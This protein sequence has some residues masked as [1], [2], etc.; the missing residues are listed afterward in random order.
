MQVAGSNPIF[1]SGVISGSVAGLMAPAADLM[2]CPTVFSL[3]SP[4]LTL[5]CGQ[6]RGA[7]AGVEQQQDDR[8][9]TVDSW[10][11]AS[12]DLTVLPGLAAVARGQLPANFFLGQRFHHRCFRIGRVDPAAGGPPYC[13][14]LAESQLERQ[15]TLISPGASRCGM[16]STVRAG[17]GIETLAGD[18]A[19]RCDAGEARRLELR[20]QL[21]RRRQPAAAGSHGPPQIEHSRG[22]DCHPGT[23]SSAA[24]GPP[25]SGS[26]GRAAAAPAGRPPGNSRCSGAGSPDR[27]PPQV[28]GA[29]C[30]RPLRSPGRSSPSSRCFRRPA[31]PQLPAARRRRPSAR[32]SVG[33]PSG[34]TPLSRTRSPAA[35]TGRGRGSRG[36]AP[37]R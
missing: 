24:G 2:V 22:R 33:W 14:R 4:N 29:G 13:A 15:R 26:R 18:Q 37:R 19:V 10:A 21:A 25:A 31:P 23:R 16:L 27:S 8:A 6:L 5:P 12:A 32:G 7:Q 20:R 9:V 28:A 36:P 35:G 34:C 17:E 30:R 1:G 11:F 3:M